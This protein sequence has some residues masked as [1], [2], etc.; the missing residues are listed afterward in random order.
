MIE[1]VIFKI[2]ARTIYSNEILIK[3]FNLT[4]I[5]NTFNNRKF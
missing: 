3:Y 5:K 2:L 1:M 4:R